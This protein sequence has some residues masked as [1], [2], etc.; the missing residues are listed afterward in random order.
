MSVTVK[1]SA[2]LLTALL[3]AAAVVVLVFG[4]WPTV[5]GPSGLDLGRHMVPMPGPQR[6]PYLAVQPTVAFGERWQAAGLDSQKFFPWTDTAKGTRDAATG[7][8]PVELAPGSSMELT[9]WGPT[10]DDRLG[11]A[12]PQLAAQALILLVLW[13][14]WRIVRTVPTAEVFTAANARRMGGIGVAVAVG[15]TVV[16]WLGYALHDGIVGRSAAAGLVDLPF[17][18]SFLP[19]VIGSVVLLLAEVFRQGVRLRAD[20]DGLV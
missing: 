6:Q 14:L 16:Q 1:V 9:F 2:R 15:G 17:S 8:P 19:P 5:L 18:F 13:L 3:G 11:F 10:W 20:V 12:V 4:V 7:L